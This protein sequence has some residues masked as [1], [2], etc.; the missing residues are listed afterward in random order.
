MMSGLIEFKCPE[1][2]A[3]ISFDSE[4]QSLKCPYCDSEINPASADELKEAEQK[5]EGEPSGEEWAGFEGGTLEDGRLVS[6]VCGSCGGEIIADENTAASVCPFCDSPVVMSGRVSGVYKPDLV[7]PFKLDKQAAKERYKRHVSGK[8]FLP[9]EFKA[10]GHIDE[11]KGIY[12]PFWLFGAD[13]DAAVSFRATKQRIWSDSDYNYRETLHYSVYRSASLSFENVPVDGSRSIS[14]SVMESIEPFD[15][16]QAVDFNEA[17][18]S[19]FL[20]DKY[21]VLSEDCFGRASDRMRTSCIREVENTV[22]GYSTR[23]ASSEKISLKNTS[24][25]YALLPVWFL[26]TSWN[27][28]RYTFAMNGQTGR[29]VGDLPMDKKQ[30]AKWTA[31]FWLASFVPAFLILLFL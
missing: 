4:A 31:L 10:E 17:Y 3:P 14:D 2:G 7:I 20:A 12:V 11:I 26:G 23:T 24:V 29:F 1:C 5:F 27:G 15:F 8:L 25:R 18:L 19:G 16:T 13:A 9:K 30:A 28:K 21:D 22:T 6:F